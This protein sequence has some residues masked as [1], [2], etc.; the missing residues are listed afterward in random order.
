MPVELLI[1]GSAGL[2]KEAAQLARQVDPGAN[3]WNRI[4]YVAET[5]SGLRVTL[6][7]GQVRYTDANLMEMDRPADVVIGIGYPTGRQRVAQRLL[8][9]PNFR[10]PNLV[11]PSVDIET[12]VVCL[13]RGNMVCKGVILT[14]DI[15]IGDFNLLNW[16]VTVG[17]DTHIDSF[18]VVNP[19]TNV[20][21]NV[22][23]SSGCLLGTG[24]QI[25]EGLE[26]AESTVVGAGAVVA[27]SIKV[28]GI[29]VGIPAR[30]L[31]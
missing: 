4:S 12:D 6:P 23:L 14:C 1:I 19:G 17:H 15:E 29:Y 2:A 11:H 16:N 5:A 24:S 21:G 26:I 8:T 20:S 30:L 3:R 22:R 28:S 10:F 25:L 27:A 13:G 31:K 7:Y 9:N 18:C